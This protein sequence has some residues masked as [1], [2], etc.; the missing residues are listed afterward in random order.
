MATDFTQD[1]VLHFLQSSGGSVK[2]SDLLLHFRNFLRNH[3]DQ[4]R[5]RELFKKFVNSVATVRQQDGV[6]HV[7]L[8]KKFKGHIPG[9]G[10]AASSGPRRPPDW[11]SRSPGEKPAVREGPVEDTPR[12]TSHQR[13]PAAG[14]LLSDTESNVDVKKQ[15]QVNTASSAQLVSEKT[16][17]K[18]PS[19]REPPVRDPC[20]PVS[21]QRGA[22]GPSPGTT[23][24][25]RHHGEDQQVV[26]V[27]QTLRGREACQHT[28]GGLHQEPPPPPPPHAQGRQRRFKY[29]QSYK[30]AVSCDESEG[31]E[32]E[33]IESRGSAGAWPHGVPLGDTGR[34]TSTS[35]P[36]IIDTPVPRSVVSSS[37]SS[38]SERIVPKIY[39]QDVEGAVL[40]PPDPGLTFNPGVGLKEGPEH[41]SVPEEPSSRP[42][43][44][45]HAPSTHPSKEASP[46]HNVQ[47][48][49]Q[50]EPRHSPTSGLSSS[51]SSVLSPSP[52]V[53]SSRG[54]GWNSSYEDLQARAGMAM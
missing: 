42:S 53:G 16:Q 27:P 21:Q 9:D 11:K 12:R 29:R 14:I 3:A 37:S 44:A 18:A 45:L 28:E 23:P 48:G 5:N 19:V 31:E 10:A 50:L 34:V 13:L 26:R 6:S 38:S 32:D 20:A 22:S 7:V 47:Q 41:M 8:R 2:N 52:D 46:H 25:V 15:Q 51:H 49:C 40:P 17:L 39:I 24:A 30:S 4:D 1:A 33:V 54:S 36:C 43:E 35:L